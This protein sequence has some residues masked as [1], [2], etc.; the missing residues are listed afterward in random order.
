MT[1][2]CLPAYRRLGL[3]GRGEENKHNKSTP[4]HKQEQERRKGVV[5]GNE[6][7]LVVADWAHN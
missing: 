2:G 5:G 1:L 4:T 3:D 6:C 7:V